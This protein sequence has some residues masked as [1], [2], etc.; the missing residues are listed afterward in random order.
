MERAYSLID[1]MP[2][3][4]INLYSRDEI[5]RGAEKIATYFLE[6]W[7]EIP[8]SVRDELLKSDAGRYALS[9]A[10]TFNVKVE[11]GAVRVEVASAV[12]NVRDNIVSVRRSLPLDDVGAVIVHEMGHAEYKHRGWRADIRRDDRETF[13]NGKIAEEV[14]CECKTIEHCLAIGKTTGWVEKYKSARDRARTE[15]KSQKTFATTPERNTIGQ[16]AGIQEI[17]NVFAD[18]YYPYYGEAWDNVHK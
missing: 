1:G 2:E 17:H 16:I 4:V 7:K 18:F 12:Y 9:I 11:Y 5:A 8:G 14:Y 13:A 15:Y 10:Y 3:N 6:C